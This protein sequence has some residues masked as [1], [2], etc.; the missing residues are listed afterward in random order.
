[1]NGERGQ[2]RSPPALV[3]IA[4]DGRPWSARFDEEA[5]AIRRAV[6]GELELFHIGSTAIPGMLA[7]PILDLLGAVRSPKRFDAAS[8]AL[9]ALGYEAM[10]PYGIAGRRYFRKIDLAGTRSHHLHVFSS[11]SPHISRHLALRDYLRAHPK[12]ADAY[13]ALKTS[14]ATR[15][16]ATWASYVEGKA[17]FVAATERDALAWREAPQGTA[18]GGVAGA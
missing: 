14:L 8:S 3:R 15:P 11:G 16:G 13:G 7:K 4:K 10:G 9:V 6:A 2:S 17:A 12:V 5:Q 18:P 1:M